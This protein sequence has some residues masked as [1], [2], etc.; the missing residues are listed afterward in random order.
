MFIRIAFRVAIQI[1]GLEISFQEIVKVIFYKGDS[2][3]DL[4]KIICACGVGNLGSVS[5]CCGKSE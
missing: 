5:G 1:S 4:T 2:G 3:H